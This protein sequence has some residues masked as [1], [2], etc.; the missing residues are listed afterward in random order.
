MQNELN[1]RSATAKSLISKC[2]NR[3]EILKSRK[4]HIDL[5]G[6][7]VLDSDL[8]RIVLEQSD[9]LL[10]TYG[11]SKKIIN[12]NSQELIEQIVT[13]RNVEVN[14]NELLYCYQDIVAG[15]EIIR[16]EIIEE[17]V[18]Y[19]GGSSKSAE[20]YWAVV[21]EISEVKHKITVIHALLDEI[22]YLAESANLHEDQR[23]L[24][25]NDRTL[26]VKLLE[27]TAATLKSPMIEKSL[28]KR[29]ERGL[30]EAAEKA[31]AKE[32]E[33]AMG[34]LADQAQILIGELVKN[35][36]WR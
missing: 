11:G 15:L 28:L 14:F 17:E 21:P 8:D 13:R 26:L 36:P 25:S 20:F 6:L 9:L 35:F 5:R 2:K 30:K 10:K 12:I 27:T 23:A 29:T 19:S 18:L 16:S 31:A 22:L 7:I 4:N 24:T 32:V 34:S 3:I 33:Q 1:F